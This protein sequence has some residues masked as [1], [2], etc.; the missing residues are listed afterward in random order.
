MEASLKTLYRE[1]LFTEAPFAGRKD[2]ACSALTA[3]VDALHDK[4][5]NKFESPLDAE[6]ASANSK[7]AVAN[8]CFISTNVIL[9]FKKRNHFMM[10]F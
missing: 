7:Y 4:L 3:F 10:S 9:F 5:W 6:F 2:D 1:H 8:M